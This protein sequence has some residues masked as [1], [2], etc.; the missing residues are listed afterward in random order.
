[1]LVAGARLGTV[2][3]VNKRSRSCLQR[4]PHSKKKKIQSRI[5][6][7]PDFSQF[8]RVLRCFFH[9]R[10]PG[11]PR[12]IPDS[13]KFSLFPLC[14]TSVNSQYRFALY[15]PGSVPGSSTEAKKP[16]AK[17]S[18]YPAMRSKTTGNSGENRAQASGVTWSEQ[19]FS[20]CDS[21]V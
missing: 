19:T 21:R 9:I 14:V 11:H 15:V 4:S 7:S 12:Q 18:I 16:V 17:H 13:A 1:M 10:R 8:L 3:H 6:F 5:F 2:L 20:P